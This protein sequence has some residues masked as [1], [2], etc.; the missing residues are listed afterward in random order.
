MNYSPVIEPTPKEVAMPSPLLGADLIAVV[1]FVTPMFAVVIAEPDR[2]DA[3]AVLGAVVAA[4]V[5]WL[6]G[7]AQHKAKATIAQSVITRVFVGSFLPGLAVLCAP[8]ILPNEW[9][10]MLASLSWHAF[11][12]MG[13]VAG[14]FAEELLAWAGEMIDRV[15]KK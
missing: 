3:Y 6:K 8:A 12:V 5:A 15:R 7:A 2:S 14:S 10:P 1:A 11:A 4:A 9:E 13:L